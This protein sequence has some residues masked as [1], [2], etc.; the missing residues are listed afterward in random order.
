MAEIRWTPRA[1]R[2]AFQLPA[3]A[4]QDLRRALDILRMFPE[5]G[6]LITE[7]RFRGNRRVRVGRYWALYYTVAGSGRTCTLRAI[8]DL[9]RRSM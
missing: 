2:A 1:E 8:R 4:R 5:S 3:N 6:F 7:G 9:R